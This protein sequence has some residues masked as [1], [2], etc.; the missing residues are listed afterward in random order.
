MQP[1]VQQNWS[2]P[3][4]QGLYDPRFEH[5]ACGI[6]FVAH[7]E[8]RRSH[9]VLEMGLEA[10][11]N[12]A[13]RGA[14]AD[15]RKTGD[16]AGILTQLPHEF[17]SRELR[18]M[19]VEPPAQG[20]LAVGQIFF[21]KGNGEDR[22]LARDL[23]QEILSELK[24]EVLAFRSVPVIESAL[25]QR[26]L[27]SRPWLGQVLVRRTDAACGAGDAFERLLYVAR[28]RIINTARARGIQRL[29]I[30]SLSSRTIVYKGLMLA[31]ELAH[32]YPDLSDPEYK[33]AI[34]V[35]HQ[36][37]STNTFPTW[38]RAQPF[39]LVCHN[40]EINTLQ[41]NENWMRA[42]EADLASPFWDDP[43]AQLI[44]IVAREGSDS[45]KF[46]NVLELLVRG[47]RDI[48]HA[49]MM[50]VPEAWERLPE[51][52]VTPERRAFYE[53]HSALMEPWDGPAALTY[54]D[55]RVVG[56]AMDRNGL[57]PARYV[58]LDNGLVICASET[59]AVAYDEG[60]V[61]RKGRIAPGQIFCVDTTRGV[62]MDDEEITQ[63]FAARRPYDKWIKENLV[64][65]D[66][67][68]KQVKSSTNGHAAT[69]GHTGHSRFT[70]HYSRF[71]AFDQPPSQLRL[72]LG[73]ADR[74]PPP[75]DHH[76]QRA[77]RR[78]GRRHAACRDEQAAAL[79][80]RLFQAAF[81]RSDQ[82]AHRP[83]ARGVGDELAHVAGQARQRAER[84][85]GGD[86]AAGA[87]VADSAARTGGDAPGADAARVRPGHGRRS[88]A[89]AGR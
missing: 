52:E 45:G 40:G 38:E 28:K 49:I 11:R 65:L 30:S 64:H 33:T 60:R 50:M 31:E 84:D 48:R 88:L 6:G 82:P 22:A 5:D 80:F 3:P 21:N 56:T 32:F 7:V 8:G 67:L 66:D 83:A 74:H 63:K 41:G 34:A 71:S 13:H 9:R 86:A 35:F 14:V 17:F 46:D 79:A 57:R 12:H 47:G 81:C 2:L 53:Y 68:A 75:D 62:I 73:G 24:L 23:I 69:N 59:G 37:Y 76:R 1:A 36:R 29:Y 19:G 85:A 44:P 87:Q 27:Y 42:R 58:V 20:D 89:G 51:G 54:T 4:R 18:R 43:Q 15:D 70:I 10:L 61:M 39:R 72:H 25:G 55:G 26:A 16:G 78:D 77:G